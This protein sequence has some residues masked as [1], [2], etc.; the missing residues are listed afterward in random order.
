MKVQI[1]VPGS[2]EVRAPLTA[3]LIS[4]AVSLLG[5]DLLGT[6]PQAMEAQGKRVRIMVGWAHNYMVV[7]RVR[8]SVPL[9]HF[10]FGTRV[11]LPGP[12]SAP[13]RQWLRVRLSHHSIDLTAALMFTSPNRAEERSGH[14]GAAFEG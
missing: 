14:A 6:K 4:A 5:Y 13:V 8:V 3:G 2:E 10:G 11:S 9:S 7:I 1:Q 12:A